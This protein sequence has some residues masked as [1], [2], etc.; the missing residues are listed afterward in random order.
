MR[1]AI[2]RLRCSVRLGYCGTEADS[3]A[4][5]GASASAAAMT[6]LLWNLQTGEA[7]ARWR[8]R[9]RP[10]LRRASCAPCDVTVPRAWAARSTAHYAI[11]AKLLNLGQCSSRYKTTLLDQLSWQTPTENKR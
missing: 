8:R 5:G 1:G 2:K 11:H 10:M 3:W 7:R 6:F 9:L 4:R